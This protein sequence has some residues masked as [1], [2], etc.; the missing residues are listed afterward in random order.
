MYLPYFSSLTSKLLSRLMAHFEK[1]L[2]KT[3]EKKGD[4]LSRRYK[5]ILDSV[6]VRQRKLFRFA[7]LVVRIR[8]SSSTSQ[9][10]FEG[11]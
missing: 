3:P 9:L 1:E 7:R 8:P 4:E 2:Q 10:T 6:R 5:S 11:S